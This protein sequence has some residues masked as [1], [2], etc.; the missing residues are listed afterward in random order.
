[1]IIFFQI[2]PAFK[3]VFDFIDNGD[4]GSENRNPPG[5]DNANKFLNTLTVVEDDRY[6]DWSIIKS[7]KSKTKA[8]TAQEI[9]S[10]L[11]ILGNHRLSTYRYYL[12]SRVTRKS[13]DF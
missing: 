7:C 9:L 13:L 12:I 8:H 2:S 4:V 10:T 11:S 3:N 5:F 1:M 6:C